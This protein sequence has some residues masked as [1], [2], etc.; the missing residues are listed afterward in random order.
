MIIHF[1]CKYSVEHVFNFPIFGRIPEGSIEIMLHHTEQRR[2]VTVIFHL[3]FEELIT[4]GTLDVH[5]K[6]EQE[7]QSQCWRGGT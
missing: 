6:L 3:I 1:S 7:L 2:A 5:R 4:T